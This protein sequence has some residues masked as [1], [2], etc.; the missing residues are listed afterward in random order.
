MLASKK[1]PDTTRTF[2]AIGLGVVIESRESPVLS[3]LS[4]YLNPHL[5]VDVLRQAVRIF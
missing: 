1:V 4:Q 2:A 3:R 5:P